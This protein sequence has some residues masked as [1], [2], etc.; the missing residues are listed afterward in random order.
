MTN[1]ICSFVN[2]P[3]FLEEF[4]KKDRDEE[5]KKR[6]RRER[7]K[8]RREKR[9]RKKREKREKGKTKICTLTIQK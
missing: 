4:V 9:E 8:E 3:S 1:C 6:E 7:E 5:R 2:Q